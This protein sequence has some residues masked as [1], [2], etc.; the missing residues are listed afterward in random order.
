VDALERYDDRCGPGEHELLGRPTLA[1]TRIEGGGPLNQV[2]GECTVS[3]DRR[4]VPPETI[5]DFVASLE[6]YLGRELPPE[7]EY[8]VRAAYPDSPNPDAFATD[9]DARLVQTLA[10]ASGGTIRAFEAATEASYFATDAP[11][12]V[13]GPGVLADE[14]GPV[15]HADR[16]Y[17]SQSAIGVAAN[18]VRQTVEAI[19]AESQNR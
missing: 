13:F 3:F 11:T 9:T 17:I 14:T 10:A 2:P 5:E 12:V 7:Y 8:E 15:A 19:L 1:V 16:E 6:A 18:A 4:T